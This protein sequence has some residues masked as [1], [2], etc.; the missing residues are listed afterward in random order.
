MEVR[1]LSMRFVWKYRRAASKLLFRRMIK[2]RIRSPIVSF[3]FDDA[4]KT[5]FTNGGGILNAYGAKGTFYVSLGM[6]GNESPSG[7]IASS[8][9][10]RRAVEEGHELGCHTFDHANA[11]ETK[12]EAFVQSVL[13]N[14]QTLSKILF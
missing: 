2:L 5:S 10:L 3:S 8:G 13:K 12:T 1:K 6:L 11:W 7:S 14:C 9:D 4:P